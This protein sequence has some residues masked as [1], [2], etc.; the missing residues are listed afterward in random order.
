MPNDFDYDEQKPSKKRKR[1]EC[2]FE[3]KMVQIASIIDIDSDESADSVAAEM[4]AELVNDE[5]EGGWEFFRVDEISVRINPGCLAGLL[6]VAARYRNYQV[7][8]FRRPA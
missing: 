4:L 1:S 8:T 3:Y 7:V 2:P 6:G 5:T